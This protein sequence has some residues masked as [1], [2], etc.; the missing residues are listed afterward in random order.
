[1]EVSGLLSGGAPVIKKYQ[2]NATVANAG[3]PLLVGAAG[4]AGLDL[5]TTTGAAD[6]VGLNLDT[7]TYTT[8]QGTGA[9]SA[10]RLVSVII[11]PDAILKARMSG[12]A[13]EGT[14]LTLYDVTTASAGGTAITTGDDWSSPEF[15]EG[16]VWGYDGANVGQVRKI[17]S[18]STTAGTVLVPFDYATVV[19]DNFL[20]APYWTM[21]GTTVQLTTNFYE[22]DASI[23][24][25]T[26]AG[27]KP[28]DLE[29]NDLSGDGRNTSYVF[30]LPTDHFLS[31]VD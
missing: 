21:Q 2:I 3:V 25:G 31:S 17:T 4:E 20:R 22:A 18:T 28:I 23:A 15:D 12:G 8:T 9:S 7:A 11:N 6:V 5:P 1:M 13:T 10:E 16:V 19:G 30:M 27:F 14:A 29:L 24:V 26:G